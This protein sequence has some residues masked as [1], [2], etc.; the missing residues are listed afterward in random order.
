MYTEPFPFGKW[1]DWDLGRGSSA[2]SSRFPSGG[3]GT[4][5]SY[6][7]ARSLWV[8]STYKSNA[9]VVGWW[10]KETA[11][12]GAAPLCCVAAE[13]GKLLSRRQLF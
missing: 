8:L 13:G 6:P 3:M 1:V 10:G 4:Y 5:T 9:L 11:A 12:L 2:G 7:Y